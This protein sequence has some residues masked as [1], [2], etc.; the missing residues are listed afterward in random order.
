[1]TG[2]VV[3]G[4]C[5]SISV[6]ARQAD[7]ALAR[8]GC[9]L[10]RTSCLAF[11]TPSNLLVHA[12][13]ALRLSSFYRSSVFAR[14]GCTCVRSQREMP[15]ATRVCTRPRA[16]LQHPSKCLPLRPCNPPRTTVPPKPVP[17]AFFHA[18][19]KKPIRQ[20]PSFAR[21][22]SSDGAARESDL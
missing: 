1:M 4:C 7:R 6:E 5:D 19:E 20:R 12:R 14:L 8:T 22:V 16:A 10:F 13:T 3:G 9:S 17:F 21:G 11:R 2:R 15:V 18:F